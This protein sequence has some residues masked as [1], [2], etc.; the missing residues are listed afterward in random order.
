MAS[1]R[2]AR[3]NPSAALAM[4]IPVLFQRAG[5]ALPSVISEEAWKESPAPLSSFLQRTC[6]AFA[7][8]EQP[9]ERAVTELLHVLG[10][11]LFLHD[12][13]TE[14]NKRL[15]AQRGQNSRSWLSRAVPPLSTIVCLQICRHVSF[16]AR[17][18]N[19][20]EPQRPELFQHQRC[21]CFTSGILCMYIHIQCPQVSRK[22]R[23][24]ES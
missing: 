10:C 1:K 2:P 19:P 16:P 24:L 15:L 12:S 7:S 22:P 9:R 20:R 4:H 13:P 14:E 5:A 11:V 18:F 6:G 8:A 17:R 21:M 3:S 23:E